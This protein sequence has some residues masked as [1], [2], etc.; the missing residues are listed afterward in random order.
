MLA[1]DTHLFSLSASVLMLSLKL[2]NVG[3][4]E[5]TRVK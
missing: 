5:K 4:N 2:S 3:P 1:I